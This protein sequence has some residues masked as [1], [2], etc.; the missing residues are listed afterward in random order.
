MKIS[1]PVKTVEA[2]EAPSTWS[3]AND[4]WRKSSRT[5]GGH[6]WESDQEIEARMAKDLLS[7]EDELTLARIESVQGARSMNDGN[8]TTAS[9]F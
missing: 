4:P 9:L 5:S 1:N 2:N 7:E 3:K 6:E 8:S